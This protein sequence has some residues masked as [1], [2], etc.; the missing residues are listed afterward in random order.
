MN[1]KFL[2]LPKGATPVVPP[3]AVKHD[4]GKLRYDLI[5]AEPF[6]EVVLV[7]TNGALTYADRNWELGMTWGRVFGAMLRH[8]WAFWRGE[9]YDRECRNKECMVDG[10]RTILPMAA[11]HD[12]FVPCPKCGLVAKRQEH[13]AA[14][15][16]CALGLMEY[17]NTH[18]ELDD[19]PRKV[20][21]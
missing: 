7:Y 16:W 19:R 17:E 13:L 20:S 3:K 6:E 9:R 14:V 11:A 2:V 5:P 21:A 15:V 1:D 4:D 10:R 18:P 8:A 12:R